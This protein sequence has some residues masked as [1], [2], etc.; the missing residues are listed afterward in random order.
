[1]AAR[2]PILTPIFFPPFTWADRKTLTLAFKMKRISTTS[3][4]ELG[5]DVS[6]AEKEDSH[7]EKNIHISALTLMA[8]EFSL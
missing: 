2:P 3:L 5:S 6:R 4:A 1:M 8:E 7:A